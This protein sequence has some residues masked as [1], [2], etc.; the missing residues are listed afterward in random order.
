MSVSSLISALYA[1]LRP[2]ARGYPVDSRNV[3]ALSSPAELLHAL[4]DCISSARQR[5]AL[6]SLYV[7]AEGPHERAV[8]D[9]VAAASRKSK[10]VD[11]TLL[12]DAR[13]ACR[14]VGGRDPGTSSAAACAARLLPA[15]ARVY[16]HNVPHPLGRALPH[17]ARELLGVSHVKA[18]VFD[19]TVLW[20]GA[21]LSEQYLT[22]RQDRYIIIRNA[23]ELADATCK[24]LQT[25]HSHSGMLQA[26]A[27]IAWPRADDGGAENSKRSTAALTLELM[28]MLKPSE[29]AP[30]K[31]MQATDTCAFLTMQAGYAGLNH[32]TECISAALHA[33]SAAE[34]RP[35]IALATPYCNL[36]SSPTTG[37]LLRALAAQAEVQVLT[38]SP[39]SHAWAG[40]KAT[41]KTG[42]S[43]H[44]APAYSL[45]TH[46]TAEALYR[47]R[48]DGGMTS[49]WEYSTPGRPFHAKGLWIGHDSSAATVAATLVGS[50]NFGPRSAARDLEMNCMLVTT[51]ESLQRALGAEWNG[52]KQQAHHV[53]LEQL[54]QRRRECGLGAAVVASVAAAWM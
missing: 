50:T 10:D 22:Q 48:G 15:G 41:L 13:R 11:V 43:A 39:A 21:N 19:D 35:C 28:T 46:Q 47:R 9:A 38:A 26:D 7:G 54:A 8:L 2:L 6:A 4:H 33:V 36:A 32:D 20:T 30:N 44:V 29:A 53:S 5:I 40:D 14:P 1:A 42:V 31:A 27:S 51:S 3:S 16:L 34:P 17:R 45:L 12:M 37:E 23:P 24:L 18:A 52:L 49:W 25:V